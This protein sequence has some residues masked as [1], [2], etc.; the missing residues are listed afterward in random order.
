METKMTH[1][2]DSTTHWEENLRKE[3]QDFADSIMWSNDSG[4]E[5]YIGVGN[6]A[7]WWIDKI[8]QLK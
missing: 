5:K 3:F 8:K 6:M 4:D 2:K 1:S 7:D